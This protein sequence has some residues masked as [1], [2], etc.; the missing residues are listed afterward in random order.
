MRRPPATTRHGHLVRHLVW[1]GVRAG[2]AVV[3]NGPKERRQSWVFV[4][5]VVNERTGEE[6]IEVRGG[7]AGEAKGRSFSPELIFPLSARRGSSLRGLSLAAAP[8][9]PLD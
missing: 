8:Q 5:H 6:W 3:V 4:A 7:R 9:L 2:D 1:H